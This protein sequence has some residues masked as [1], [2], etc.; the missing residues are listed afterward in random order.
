KHQLLV[1][2]FVIPSIFN[3]QEIELFQQ[4]NGRYDYLSFGNTLN[5]QENGG[6]V[7]CDILTEA[8][9]EFE[10][11]ADQ[12]II[13]AYLYWAGSGTGDFEVTFA[14]INIVAERTF[15]YTLPNTE[16]VYFGAFVDVTT[17]VATNGN[18]TYLLSDLDLQEAIQ[19]YCQINGGNAT[20][21]GGWG[22][23]VVYQDDDLPLNQVNIFD[24]FE[25]VSGA[26][27][28][29]DIELNN[30][31]VLDNV[32]AK[33]GFLAWEGDLNI[34][35]NET[36]QI[37]GNTLSNA[38]NP[39]DNQFNGTN[40]FTNN[41]E[42]YN[43]DIDFY[44]IESNIQPG[45][46][47]ALIRITSSQDLVIINNVITV[48][49][50]ELPDA[51]VE[52]GLITG[53]TDCGDREITELE[54]TVFNVNSTAPLPAGTRVGFYAQSLLMDTAFTQNELPIGGSESGSIALTIPE[55]VPADFVLRAVVDDNLMVTEANEDNNEDMVEFHLAVFPNIG[56]LR[57]LELC[58][59]VG[60]G[61]FDLTEATSGI[62]PDD[63]ISF[64]L[65]EEDAN[66]DINPIANTEDY[67]NTSN[68]QVIWV[69]VSNPDCFVVGS[70]EIEIIVCPLPDATISIDSEI[71]ACR[72]RDLTIDYTVYNLKGTAPLPANTPIAF[73]ANGD[74]IAQAQTVNSISEGGSENNSIE[75]TLSE[76]I[77]NNFVLLAVV[78][79]TGVGV[80]VIQELDESNNE[81][82]IMAEFGT[83]P[84]IP[85]LP[86]LLECDLG[87]DTAIFD[88]TEQNELISTNP[89]DQISYF[90]T[91]ENAIANE[92][93][94]SDP[95]QYEN[96]VDPQIIFVRLENEICFT[97]ASFLLTTENC[98]P[99]I[100][101]GISPNG[102]TLN[103]EFIITGL[104]D[105][106]LD[107]NL[108]IYSREGNL[109]YEGGNDDGLWNG[110]PNT[111]LLVQ[112]KVVPVGTYYYV[113]ILND[114]EFSDAFLGYLY[115]NY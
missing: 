70:F 14:G 91:L 19:T 28:Q 42:F 3:A 59:V 108:K 47:S 1:L 104:I 114:P 103:D 12:T 52:I 87:L 92:N 23:T 56:S 68:P 34:S 62:D 43:M 21:F 48:L 98:K 67:E 55:Q 27:P 74:L 78:D 41:T 24:G 22:V 100:T 18:G 54:Y 11:A 95:E 90:T 25:S 31:N 102:D 51:T 58:D 57:N 76:D 82:E 53:A 86:D 105:V 15:S 40:S 6:G 65:T 85:T 39:A 97:T 72:Q 77:P 36:L 96:S 88:L 109:I 79:D 29:L 44:N 2:L 10:L 111:G 107:F 50:T 38:L 4:F 33:L 94:I 71:Y 9:A 99:I 113:L 7:S 5:L 112:N 110:I 45:D 63:S 49:N 30:L 16:S 106:F 26:N 81:F 37:N 17:I 66:N 89:N 32:G 80:G 8:S 64:H 35:N 75:I 101:Q 61:L 69:R 73:Y 83:I 46:Q 93:A 60:L 13:A 20:N 115:V 84:P